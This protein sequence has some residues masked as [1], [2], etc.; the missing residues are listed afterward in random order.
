MGINLIPWLSQDDGKLHDS[1][2]GYKQR[3]DI[4]HVMMY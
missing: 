2:G 4:S 1:A 3:P